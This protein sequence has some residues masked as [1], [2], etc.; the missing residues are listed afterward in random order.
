VLRKIFLHLKVEKFP[1]SGTPVN[2]DETLDLAVD[3]FSDGVCSTEAKAVQDGH[4]VPFDKRFEVKQF[5]YL[6]LLD[7][8]HPR[9]F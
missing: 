9:S 4:H 8:F 2:G 1:V 6:I 5:V 3:M 7:F